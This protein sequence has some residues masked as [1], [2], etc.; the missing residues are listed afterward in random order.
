MVARCAPEATRRYTT[1]MCMHI[2][3]NIYTYMHTYAPTIYVRIIHPPDTQVG[4][5]GE[6][7]GVR[8][9]DTSALRCAS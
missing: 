3:V 7:M 4:G 8:A 6:G 1:H 5:K 2:Y 9:S